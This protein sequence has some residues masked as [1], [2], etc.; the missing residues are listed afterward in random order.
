MDAK[1]FRNLIVRKTLRMLELHSEAAEDLLMGTAA[2]ESHLKYIKQLGSGPALGLFQMEPDTLHDIWENYLDYR[3]G[4][5]QK[6]EDTT[7]IGIE[8]Q[9]AL[10]YNL[11][12]A[13]AMCRVHYLR[14]SAPLPSS[15]AEQAAYW[16]Q[17]YNTVLG[18]GTVEEYIDNYETKVA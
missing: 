16:K 1:Q 12:Y 17:H 11:R 4:L 9:D 8:D 13:A 14:V 18:A 7:G 5:V 2:Q 15:L 10:V 6:I 3:P